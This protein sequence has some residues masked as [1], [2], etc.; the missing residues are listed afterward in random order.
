MPACRCANLEAQVLE[1]VKDDNV[2]LT[3]ARYYL[4]NEGG[5][6]EQVRMQSCCRFVV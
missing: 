5:P 3:A 6:I 1:R 4:F 2:M